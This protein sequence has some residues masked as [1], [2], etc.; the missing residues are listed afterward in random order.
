MSFYTALTGLKGAQTD[1]ATTSNNIANVGSSG[2]KKSRAEF[3]DIFGTTPL[4]T[5]TVGSGTVTKSIKQQFS[6]GNISQSTNTLDMAVSGQ[7]FFALKGGGNAGQTVFTRNGSF[8]VNDTGFIVDS[9]GQ[10]LLG[11]PVDNDGAVADKTLE[12]A[13][14]M[15]LSASFGEPVATKKINAGVNLPSDAPVIAADVAFDANDAKTYSASSSVTIFDNGGNPKSATVFY[16]KSQNPVAADQTFKYSTKMFVDGVEI[17]PE[18]TR[19]TDTKGV[20]QFI[21]KFGQKTTAP[22][23]INPAYILQGKGSQLYRAD[24]L[25]EATKSTPAMLTGL[26]LEAFLG[27]GKTVEIVTDP[28]QFKRTMEFQALN[29]VATPVP[30]TFWGKDFLLVDVDNSGPVSID[31]PPGIYTGAQ[32]ADATEVALRDAFGDDKKVQLTAGVDSTFTIDFKKSSGDGKSTGLPAPIT[33]DLHEATT[34]FITNTP[35]DGMEMDEF[36]THAQTRVSTELNEYIQNATIG[37]DAAKVGNIGADGKLFKKITGTQITAAEAN[38]DV[39]TVAHT[40]GAAATTTR[41]IGYSNVN[42]KPEVK[43]YDN[44][45]KL[46]G[47]G[48][49]NAAANQIQLIDVD[50]DGYLRVKIK[51]VITDDLE[52]FRF[53]QNDAGADNAKVEFIDRVGTGEIAVKSFT[54]DGTFTTFILDKIPAGGMPALQDPMR[55]LAKPSDHIEAY[56]EDTAGLVE[57]VDDVYYSNK[58]IVREIGDSAKRGTTVAMQARSFATWASTDGVALAKYGLGGTPAETMNWVDERNPALKIGYDENNQRLTFDGVN[59]QLGKG[60][61]VG[62]DN[63]TVYSQKLDAGKNGLGIPAL[64]ENPEISL[65]TD[66]LLL[67]DPFVN[68]GPEI[69]VNNKRYGMEV[70]FDTVNNVFNVSSGSTGEALAGGSVVGVDL[71]QNASS[72]AVGRYKLTLA[73]GVDGTDKADY[74]ANKIGKGGNQI[75]GFPRAGVEGYRPP[76]GLVSKPAVVVGLEGLMDMT[77]PFTITSLANENVFNVVVGGVS[78]SIVIPEGNYKGDTLATALEERINSMKNPISGQSVGGVD[79]KY[80]AIAN[81]LTFTTATTGEG[82]T[83]AISAALK[84]G[85]KDIPLGLGET[86]MVRQPVQATDELGR[87]LFISPAGEIVANN[88]DF[89]DNMVENFYPLY[90]DEGELTF[91]RDGQIVSPITDVK[92]SGGLTELTLD[93]STATQLDQP[94]SAREVTQDGFSAGR[95]TNLEIDNYGN[96]NA[97]YSNGQNVTLGK[98][99]LASFAS[100]SGLKQIGNSTFIA[101]AASGDPELGEGAEDGFGQILSGS[102]ERSNVDITEELVNLITSQRNY[103]AAAKAIE[104]SSSMTQ[105]IIN[106]RS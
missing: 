93:F 58:I 90:L 104:T 2:F 6:Q 26:G 74:E 68:D 12:G 69:R 84:F 91:D 30:G 49:N 56:F 80:D 82:N 96:V 70:E 9:N 27:D 10:F 25:G 31:I 79:V 83:L 22:T 63:F 102:I 46:N 39:L 99:M 67:G 36:L 24:D 16:I 48:F 92:Y 59:A 28:L 42:D 75:M 98:I 86:T 85:L 72:V 64:G 37:V 97:G 88:Q 94:F 65:K 18:L 23:E 81:N 5:N 51:A 62:F 106:I 19:A 71:A 11:Y 20:T 1:I 57:G 66:N 34:N 73:G 77:Q 41:Y 15:K 13:V 61:G 7:G 100:E 105:T 101:T 78:A 40:N 29:N 21:D 14:Q 38:S 44:L 53:Q 103:Q 87:P 76:S 54:N 32:L 55:I 8:E 47:A 45:F 52:V 60:T 33:I 89:A 35:A 3:G 4:Q 17:K 50:A 43:A 95:L